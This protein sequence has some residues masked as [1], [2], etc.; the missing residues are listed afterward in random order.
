[1][2]ES[3]IQLFQSLLEDRV[4]TDPAL[5]EPYNVDWMGILR[6]VGGVRLL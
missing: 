6:L 3:D 2:D 5:V 1:M 4:L